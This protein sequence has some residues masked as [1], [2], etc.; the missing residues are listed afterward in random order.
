MAKVPYTPSPK[1]VTEF[2]KAIQGLGTPPKVNNAYLPTIGFKSSNDRYLV[3][4]CKYL[5]FVD[6]TGVPTASW[7][8]FRDKA[9]A[10]KVMAS[11]IRTAY[12]DLYNTYPDAENRDDVTLQNYFAST[13]GVAQSVSKLM[14]Q[15][16]KNLCEYA[17]FEAAAVTETIS[18]PTTPSTKEVAETTAA[19][20][21]ITV[22]INIQLQLPATEDAMIYDSLF[23]ALKKHLFS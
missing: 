5:G 15:T 22:N 3:G 13:S 4:L 11:A 9:K 16:F 6:S 14:V 2:F 1:N 23:S 20:R 10:P 18:T 21:P 12:A 8:D 17:D 7:S 19:A